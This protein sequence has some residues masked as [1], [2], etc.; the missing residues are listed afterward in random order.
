MEIAMININKKIHELCVARGW[1]LYTLSERT[2]IPYSTLNSSINRNSPPKIDTLQ[3][4]CDAFGIT[5]AQFFMYDEDS[6][7]ISDTEKE[8]LDCFRA[9][10]KEKQTLLI[11]L[12]KSQD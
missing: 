6:V 7:I 12:L 9:M 10:N 11:Q 3:R 5:L 1:T 8:L 4:I 2:D